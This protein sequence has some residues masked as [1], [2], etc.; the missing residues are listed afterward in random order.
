MGGYVITH[1]ARA[2][3]VDGSV[4]TS[5]EGAN[6]RDA[7]FYFFSFCLGRWTA[8]A[9]AVAFDANGD[10]FREEWHVRMTT[11][12]RYVTT[13]WASHKADT[14]SALFT[15]FMARLHDPI[16]K[17]V[18]RRSIW[19][20]I[21]ANLQSGGID[22]GIILSQVA[23]EL[24]AW[25]VFVEGGRFITQRG[26]EELPTADKLRLLLHRMRVPQDIPG[27]RSNLAA[28]GG[29]KKAQ[30]GAYMFVEIRNAL[31]HPKNRAT[32]D[33]ATDV[34]IDAWELGLR[35]TELAILFV[36]DYG[37]SY[38]NR[39]VAKWANHVEPVPWT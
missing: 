33:D 20:H 23:L 4:F 26:F 15:G 38:T 8:P 18:L 27:S 30:Y 39:N 34:M 16:W 32:I 13:W 19:W 31:V 5:E 29:T 9:S 1:V 25:V 28:F 36:C 17:D 2:E 10:L 22:G 3:R 14:L 24:I 11:S 21:S 37:G 12:C 35:Y 7:L 6:L